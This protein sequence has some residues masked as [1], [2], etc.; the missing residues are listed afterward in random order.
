VAREFQAS[1]VELLRPDHLVAIQDHGELEPILSRYRRHPAMQVHRF[2]VHPAVRA[3]SR[4]WRARYREERFRS[5]FTGS[6][7]M[8]IDTTGIAVT[9]RLP[10]TFRDEDWSG[11][12]LGL[13]DADGFMLALAVAEHCDPARG[14]IRVVAPPF[15]REALSSVQVGTIR[16]HL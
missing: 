3:R 5:A 2:P 6:G 10:G 16:L 7:S 15:D 1:L 9:G 8:E 14:R 11:L 13:N 4:T 12:L